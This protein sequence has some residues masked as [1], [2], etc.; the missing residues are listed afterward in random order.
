MSCIRFN[1][2]AQRQAMRDHAPVMLTPEQAAALH[3]APPVTDSKIARLRTLAA[4]PNPK[5]RESVASSYHAPEDLFEKL[6]KDS[7]EGVRSW[8]A[9]NENVSCDILRSLADDESE[10]VRGWLALNFFVPDDVMARLADDPDDTVRALVR[11]K[12]AL[13]SDEL[14]NA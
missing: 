2:P 7:D 1:T 14:T 4:S 3:P 5:I 11:W 10:K 9:R 13:A 12:A 8:L 6:A